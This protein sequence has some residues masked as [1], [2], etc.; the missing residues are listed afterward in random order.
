M[1]ATIV[2]GLS[3]GENVNN[4]LREASKWDAANKLQLVV[5]LL[6]QAIKE[7]ADLTSTSPKIAAELTGSV[8]DAGRTGKLV[9]LAGV[10]AV[11][12][13]ALGKDDFRVKSNYDSCGKDAMRASQR[14]LGAAKAVLRNVGDTPA[15]KV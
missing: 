6:R 11:V 13:R 9:K 5:A 8:S 15:A 7:V 1:A 10:F 2:H 12:N 4:E 14:L 3:E